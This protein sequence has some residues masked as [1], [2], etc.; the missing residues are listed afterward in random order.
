MADHDPYQLRPV[1]DEEYPELVRCFQTVFGED[2]DEEAVPAFR[3]LTELD[4]TLAVFHQTDGVVG[5]A[6][7]LSWQLSVPGAVLPAA[8]VT[9]VSVLP[10]HRRRGLLRRLM[11]RQLTD[12]AAA[13]REPLAV[14]WA[15]ESGIYGRFG[16]GTASRHVTYDADTRAVGLRP[17]PPTGQL[18][19]VDYNESAK[20]L[21]ATYRA[22]CAE[23]PGYSSRPDEVWQVHGKDLARWREGRS[24]QRTVL[25]ER[26]GQPTGYAV[27]RIER[28]WDPAGPRHTVHVSEVVATDLGAYRDLWAFLFSI[29]LSRRLTY[30]HAALD[31][32]LPLL[33]DEP[34]RLD[35][36]LEDGL[37]VRLVDVPAA[38]SARRYA[39]PLDVV[40]EVTDSLLPANAARFHLHTTPTTP[41][42][43]PAGATGAGGA[44]FAAECVATGDP[45]DLVLDVRELGAA[46]LGGVPLTELA[47]AG[48]VRETTP[49]ALPAAST[50]FGWHRAPLGPQVF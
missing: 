46:Y 40:L 44:G 43:Q 14:L 3:A 1:T 18:R 24:R 34:R 20:E 47:L 4:R 48:R 6:V 45:A 39:A 11:T 42:D 38:L 25:H 31:E 35:T 50:A 13:G 8:H 27:W 49:G 9:D 19:L 16:Y 32:P 12:V 26:D 17:Q 33:V 29:D 23:R 36:R 30:G 2:P 28:A 5:T 41:A 7:A 10:T 22:V 21:A 15:S 37:Y